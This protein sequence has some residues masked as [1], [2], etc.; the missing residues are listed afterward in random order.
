M[1][2]A[3][4]K[5]A[6]SELNSYSTTSISNPVQTVKKKRT[7]TWLSLNRL[8][9]PLGENQYGSIRSIAYADGKVKIE[10]CCMTW[11]ILNPP[12]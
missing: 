5:A 10:C 11:S 1:N 2:S 3:A 4:H 9:L 6:G 7:D 12:P 8:Q